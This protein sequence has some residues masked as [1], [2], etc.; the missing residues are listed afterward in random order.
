MNSKLSYGYNLMLKSN[1]LINN[2][3][4]NHLPRTSTQSILVT[5]SSNNELEPMTFDEDDTLI[6]QCSTTTSNDDD[7]QQE[8]NSLDNEESQQQQQQQ[9]SSSASYSQFQMI[10]PSPTIIYL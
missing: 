2:T 4:L 8:L 7:Y 9:Q 5:N 6:L 3:T 1:D 10:K